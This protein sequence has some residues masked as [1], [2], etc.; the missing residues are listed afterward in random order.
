MF[1]LV[2]FAKT[3][4]VSSILFD[5]ICQLNII[6]WLISINTV[7]AGINSTAYI[8]FFMSWVW[9]LFEGGI[10]SRVKKG[11]ILLEFACQE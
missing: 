10:Y 7:F 5:Y 4:F 1:D 2:W 6:K 9:H 3:F 8:Y 11:S